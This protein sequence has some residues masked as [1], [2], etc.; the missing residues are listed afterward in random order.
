MLSVT[1]LP[2]RATLTQMPLHSRGQKGTIP[3]REQRKNLEQPQHTTQGHANTL[4]G[5]AQIMHGSKHEEDH[6]GNSCTKE[7]SRICGRRGHF[8][9]QTSRGRLFSVGMDSNCDK[10]RDYWS[11]KKEENEASPLFLTPSQPGF[12]HLEKAS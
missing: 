8:R 2:P 11:G 4:T 5:C 3:C 7:A 1:R 10:D 12:R 6:K 9:V